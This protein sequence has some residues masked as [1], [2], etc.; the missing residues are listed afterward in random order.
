MKKVCIVGGGASALFCALFAKNCEVT[1][2]E[3]AEKVGKKIL[4]TG[5]GRCNLSNL[6]MNKCSYIN[7]IF[8]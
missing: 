2:F 8:S 3:K 6:N 7:Y 5:N 1:I 4:A